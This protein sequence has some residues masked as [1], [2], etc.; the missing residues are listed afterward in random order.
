MKQTIRL[1]PKPGRS[2]P[3]L[4][5]NRQTPQANNRL[6]MAR[7]MVTKGSACHECQRSAGP[8]GAAPWPKAG[9]LGKDRTAPKPHAAV[10]ALLGELVRELSL[11]AEL[12]RSMHT[13]PM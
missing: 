7:G 3:R 9:P 6:E 5:R 2:R 1:M 8:R 12:F 4:P 10:V 11:T 13:S